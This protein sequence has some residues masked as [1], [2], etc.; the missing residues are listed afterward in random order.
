MPVTLK[1]SLDRSEDGW[2]TKQTVRWAGE[3]RWFLGFTEGS[4]FIF[5]SV[6]SYLFIF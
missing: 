6:S 5:R 4:M 1:F 2:G 3:L